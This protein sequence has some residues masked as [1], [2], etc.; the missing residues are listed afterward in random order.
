M[1]NFMR[2]RC[3]MILV[4]LGSLVAS[5]G[6]PSPEPVAVITQ[7]IRERGVLTFVYHG[8]ERTV[9]PHALGKTPDGKP[10]LLGWQTAG[11]SNTEPPPGWRTFVVGEITG[12]K[13][14]GKTFE[15]PRGDYRTQNTTLKTVDVEVTP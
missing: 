14:A 2:M 15:K 12:L 4:F 9:E 3:W 8:H 6:E 7:A 5:A 1:M 10:A 11:G 13:R